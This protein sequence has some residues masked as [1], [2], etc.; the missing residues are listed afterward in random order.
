MSLWPALECPGRCVLA[1]PFVLLDAW[2][3]GQSASATTSVPLKCTIKPERDSERGERQVGDWCTCRLYLSKNASYWPVTFLLWVC[4]Y[5][6]SNDALWTVP[7]AFYHPGE[8]LRTPTDNGS[9]TLLK[10]GTA[11]R[12]ITLTCCWGEAKTELQVASWQTSKNHA[13]Q[14]LSLPRD[15]TEFVLA[16]EGT[17]SHKSTH[18][19]K[20]IW[21][22]AVWCQLNFWIFPQCNK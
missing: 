8:G 11:L 12:A 20:T 21:T 6:P 1:P 2:K 7:F 17:P 22:T 4:M 19:Q 18:N 15:P 14:T 9:S 10:A 3:L 16:M 5:I 13:I